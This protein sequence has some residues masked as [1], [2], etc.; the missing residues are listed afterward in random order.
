MF[1]YQMKQEFIDSK[2]Y[3]VE[4]VKY[5]KENIDVSEMRLFN[6]YNFG[7]YLLHHDIP[8]YIDSRADLY[9][10]EYSGL[11]YD[12]F[13]D[14]FF[15]A[16][17]YSEKFEFYNITHVLIYKKVD[18]NTYTNLYVMLDKD[19]NYK[20]LYEDEEFI[21]FEKNK[22]VSFLVNYG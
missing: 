20:M 12:I 14:F 17:N 3:P 15:M 4:A 21:L 11:D 1:S 6:E 10:S 5:I 16:N 13:D 8:V 7:S 22:E 9:T 19:P 18:E 2:A